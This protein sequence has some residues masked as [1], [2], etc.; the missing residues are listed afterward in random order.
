MRPK[1]A[2]VFSA[3]AA[4][5][6][7]ALT[8]GAEDPAKPAAQIS[9]AV[10]ESALTTIALTPEAEQ[11]LG[12]VVTKAEQ[13]ALARTRLFAGQV[14][15]PLGNPGA[16]VSPIV[17]QLGGADSVRLAEAQ[18]DADG[19]VAVAR[20]QLDGAR[21]G[22]ARAEQMLRDEAGSQR[23]VDEARTQVAV[24]EAALH[25]ARNRRALLGSAAQPTEGARLW[26][27]VP[28]YAG[29]VGEIDAQGEG[30]V[31]GASGRV[32]VSALRAL[33][34]KKPPAARSSS[35][36]VDLFYELRDARGALRIGQQV[37][38]TLPLRSSAEHLVV[39]WSAVVHDPEGGSWVYERVA[40]RTYTRRRVQ[41]AYV[42][43]A[44]AALSAGM[45]PG[46]AIV[47]T[48]AAELFGT[49]FGAGK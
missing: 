3:I 47:S 43:G 20:A 11:R 6:A 49:E 24:A 15:A 31:G 40:E 13:R 32:D 26:V 37:G 46:S 39:P 10:T 45:A 30:I 29:D 21:R 48:G 1:L 23:E 18:V 7:L 14:I 25:A 33:P 28:V 35:P 41:V 9:N 36:A 34:V 12:I 27:R 44:D 2:L 42:A 19:G 5:V 17:S 16:S 8:A 38:V 4:V 22:L